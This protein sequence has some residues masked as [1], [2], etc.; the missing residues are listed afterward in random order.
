MSMQSGW[1]IHHE[2]HVSGYCLCERKREKDKRREMMGRETAAV[3]QN[4]NIMLLTIQ[5]FGGD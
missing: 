3:E 1:G 4:F 5:H 2:T